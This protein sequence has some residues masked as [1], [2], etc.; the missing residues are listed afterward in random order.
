MILARKRHWHVRLATCQLLYSPCE[1][2]DSLPSQPSIKGA[3][4]KRCISLCAVMDKYVPRASFRSV[5]RQVCHARV[6]GERDW[7]WGVHCKSLKSLRHQLAKL[8]RSAHAE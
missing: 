2:S 4:V 3:G 6:R 7:V 5:N 1:H 8:V